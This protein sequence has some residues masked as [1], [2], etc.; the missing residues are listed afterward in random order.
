[1]EELWLQI[2]HTS[3]RGQLNVRNMDPEIWRHWVLIKEQFLLVLLITVRPWQLAVQKVHLRY[4][5]SRDPRV[6]SKTSTRCRCLG[7]IFNYGLFIWLTTWDLKKKCVA[8][9]CIS[10]LAWFI[11]STAVWW[12]LWQPSTVVSHYGVLF[13]SPISGYH[14]HPMHSVPSFILIWGWGLGFSIL[15]S[16][17]V[18]SL[19]IWCVYISGSSSA[20]C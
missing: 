14:I 5:P 13:L 18:S 17:L 20:F 10:A 19:G 15:S 16:S 11:L 1:M 3:F 12:F 9:I 6:T 4:F 7:L 8:Y 2:L